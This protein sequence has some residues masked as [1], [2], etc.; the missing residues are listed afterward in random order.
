M[1]I[2]AIL[3]VTICIKVFFINEAFG[4]NSHSEKLKAVLIVGHLEDRTQEAVDEMDKIASL[5]KQYGIQVYK[6]YDKKAIWENIVKVSN[7]C[8]FF[9][10]SGHGSIMGENANAGGICIT[11]MIST[12]QLIR[13]LRLKKNALVIFKS[14]CNGAG[15]SASD[16]KDIG[17]DEAKKRVTHYA[18]PFFKVGASAYYANNWNNGGYNFLQGFLN[19]TSLKQAFI[20]STAFWTKIEFEEPFKRDYKKSISIASSDEKG[21]I[22]RTTYING[23]KKEEKVAR[24]KDY[25]IAYVGKKDFSIKNINNGK[26][27]KILTR[28]YI[29][30]SN[31]KNYRNANIMI[32]K[33]NKEGYNQPK[34]LIIDDKISVAVKEYTDI[35]ICKDELKKIRKEF[36]GAWI[37]KN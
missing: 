36:K 28:Y 12:A 1:R 14:V 20:K 26:V 24:H 35:N 25:S 31:H 4:Q 16:N 37:Y 32:K 15:S 5:L 6:F 29:I 33:L 34:I 30:V 27:C 10:Y 3:L 23:I 11:S 13:E 9:I 7:E 2:K 21:W 19:G 8:N 17:V 18:Y 22:T